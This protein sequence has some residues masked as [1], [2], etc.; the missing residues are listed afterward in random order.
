VCFADT[1]QID[2]REYSFEKHEYLD[3][4]VVPNYAHLDQEE[5]YDAMAEMVAE[6][7]GTRLT[8]KEFT[9]C[10]AEIPVEFTVCNADPSNGE[11]QM[12]GAHNDSDSDS[13]PND[14][15]GRRDSCTDTDT[16]PSSHDGEGEP[17]MCLQ[18]S[19]EHRPSVTSQ[20]HLVS[21]AAIQRTVASKYHESKKQRR[22]SLSV[23]KR[24]LKIISL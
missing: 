7:N 20:A 12:T 24:T 23:L 9:I 11:T 2:I 21:E 5:Y 3:F 17:P 15:F 14:G 18:Q 13:K 4:P 16:L 22:S 6:L 10:S 19:S 1:A 8:C